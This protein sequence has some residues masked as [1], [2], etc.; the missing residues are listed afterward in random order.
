MLTIA[1]GKSIVHEF[2]FLRC[3]IE[4]IKNEVWQMFYHTFAKA[5]VDDMATFALRV[6]LFQSEL[7]GVKKNLIPCMADCI[8]ECSC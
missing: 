4:L 7:S 8:C 5:V 3:Y 6:N 2:Y 1:D